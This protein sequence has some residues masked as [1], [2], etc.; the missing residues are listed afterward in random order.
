MGSGPQ[1]SRQQ[2]AANEASKAW[3]LAVLLR[4]EPAQLSNSSDQKSRTKT[5]L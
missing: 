2:Q 3:F 4:A 5:K 1:V